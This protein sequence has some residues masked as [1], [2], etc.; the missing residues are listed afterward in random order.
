VGA[1]KFWDKRTEKLHDSLKGFYSQQAD[2]IDQWFSKLASDPKGL[3]QQQLDTLAATYREAGDDPVIAH[4]EILVAA[5]AQHIRGLVVPVF[6]EDTRRP[7]VKSYSKL[8]AALTGMHHIEQ[9]GLELP[10]MSYQVSTGHSG[11]GHKEHGDL[12]YLAQGK[13]ELFELALT[14][15]KELQDMGYVQAQKDIIDHA[16]VVSSSPFH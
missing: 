10:V 16:P 6:E 14:A 13:Q 8:V 15:V 2:T 7:W 3:S 1:K 12:K 5:N 11:Q 4:N 9:D